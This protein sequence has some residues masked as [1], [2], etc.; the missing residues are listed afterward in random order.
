[1]TYNASGT[2]N[3]SKGYS[4]KPIKKHA[5]HDPDIN[6]SNK[7]IEFENTKYNIQGQLLD[8]DEL[9]NSR[10]SDY[11]KEHDAKMVKSRHQKDVYGSVD[12]YLS[13]MK[14]QPY[15]TMVATFGDMELKKELLTRLDEYAFHKGSSMALDDYVRG[16]NERNSEL[17]ITDYVT[18]V[19]EKGAPHVHAQ[20]VPMGRTKK[21][22]LRLLLVLL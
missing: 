7:N 19:D 10:Y 12:N 5:E 20:V 6:H 22:N 21:E 1:M 3:L 8:Y 4:W 18:N 13:A 14:N 2:L 11:V 16:F 17:K 9:M 15:V